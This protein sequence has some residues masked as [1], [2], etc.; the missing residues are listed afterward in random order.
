MNGVVDLLIKRAA[1][2]VG[3]FAVV[4]QVQARTEGAWLGSRL[5]LK[6]FGQ[7]DLD[8]HGGQGFFNR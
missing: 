3:Y 5:M 4:V 8:A 2:L 6:P 7:R 1:E